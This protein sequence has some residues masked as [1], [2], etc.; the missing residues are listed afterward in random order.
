MRKAL[1]KIHL[2]IGVAAALFLVILG[3]T[4][5]IIAF[6]GDMDHWLHPHFWYVPAADPKVS[7]RDL[8]ARVERQ[9][10]PARVR[11]VQ[12]SQRRD[13]AQLMQLTDGSAVTVNPYTGAVLGRRT[14]PTRT[15][16]W[17]G[18]IH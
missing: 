2:Y 7:E 11:A 3:L 9:F 1:L 13:L 10:A 5:S 16:R 6:E 14:G 17:L 12:I 8:I 15:D 18:S 4:G